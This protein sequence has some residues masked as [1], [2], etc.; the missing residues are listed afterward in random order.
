MSP[1]SILFL[2]VVLLVFRREG[3]HVRLG[4]FQIRGVRVFGGFFCGLFHFTG[5]VSAADGHLAHH[6]DEGGVD[7]PLDGKDAH[8]G[9]SFR[10][11]GRRIRKAGIDVLGG[12]TCA[13]G[14]KE[15]DF[16]L[17]KRAQVCLALFIRRPPVHPVAY[18][19][20]VIAVR[21]GC[22][23]YFRN[24]ASIRCCRIQGF[25]HLAGISC[26]ARVYNQ[27]FH[28]SPENRFV[29]QYHHTFEH[30]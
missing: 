14:F 13:H 27:K 16:L 29:K 12:G 17:R 30:I 9:I 6:G 10:E 26:A 25:G 11:A 18:E 19:N 5:V 15:D 1:L 7:G 2:P 4:F 28:H 21:R 3:F 22:R 8:D 23:F 20:H 24:R